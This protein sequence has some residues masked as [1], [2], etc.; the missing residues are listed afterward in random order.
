M[1]AISGRILRP[2]RTID[3]DGFDRRYNVQSRYC[4]GHGHAAPAGKGENGMSLLKNPSEI[5]EAL[6]D[7]SLDWLSTNEGEMRH[8]KAAA[9]TPN[10][11]LLLYDFRQL[12][13]DEATGLLK[14]LLGRTKLGA[15]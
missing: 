15:N 10:E 1:H 5:T 6:Y 12:P 8:Y 14:L 4:N 3:Q 7:A 11:A 9:L 2:G 13:D